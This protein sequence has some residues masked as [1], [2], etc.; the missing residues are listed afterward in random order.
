M[1]Q[2]LVIDGMNGALLRAGFNVARDA[3][4]RF[5]GYMDAGKI[6]TIGHSTHAIEEFLGMLSANGVTVLVD[7]RTVA[8]SRHNPQF[9]QAELSQSLAEVGISYQRITALGGLRYT[10]K[11]ATSINGAWRNPSF[12]A[13]ADYMQ[14]PRFVAGLQELI[15]VAAQEVVA[16]MCAEAVPWRCHRS[17]ISDALLVRGFTVTD[18]MGPA[19][20]RPHTLTKFAHVA[21]LKVWYPPE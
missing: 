5:N 1:G 9:G 2:F 13:Y 8:G 3:L 11:A 15:G 12:R 4:T 10:P 21:G 17:L 7:V 19:A 14:T 20:T 18:I 16:I 6:F